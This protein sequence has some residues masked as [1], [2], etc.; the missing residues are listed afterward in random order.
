MFAFTSGFVL[1]AAVELKPGSPVLA[2]YFCI[3]RPQHGFNFYA[4]LA[5]TSFS[6]D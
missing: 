6:V 5:L 1:S 3:V 4:G 2:W